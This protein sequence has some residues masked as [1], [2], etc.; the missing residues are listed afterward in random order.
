MLNATLLKHIRINNEN[1]FSG[2]LHRD[3]FVDNILTSFADEAEAITFFQDTRVLMS[4]ASFNLR[5]L[6]SNS[7]QL[8]I[9]AS[10][11]DVLDEETPTKVLGMLWNANK[12][13]LSF[14]QRVIPILD[15][16][17]KIEILKHT[18]RIFNP[19]GLLSSFTLR[20]TTLLQQIWQEKHDWDTPLLEH[21]DVNRR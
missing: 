10:N 7:A 17:T 14:Q 1:W 5:S 15:V 13:T 12:D 16:T 20:S 11:E 6:S 9:K 21:A 2:I 3:L 4:F 19:L 8:Q 18:S